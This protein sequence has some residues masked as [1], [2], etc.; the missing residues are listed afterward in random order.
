MQTNNKDQ[1]S[2]Y[3]VMIGVFSFIIITTSNCNYNENA[4]I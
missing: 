3:A 1:I 2:V 4:A